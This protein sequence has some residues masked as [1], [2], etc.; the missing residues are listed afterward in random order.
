MHEEVWNGRDPSLVRVSKRLLQLIHT[1]NDETSVK[2]NLLFDCINVF[3]VQDK[4]FPVVCISKRTAALLSQLM[5]I[6]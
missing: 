4:D 2:G 3:H 1:N 6:R 5:E